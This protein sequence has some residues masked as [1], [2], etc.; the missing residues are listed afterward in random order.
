M[1]QAPEQRPPFPPFTLSS[2]IEK[3]RK[4][5]DAWNSRDPARVALAY[6]TDSRCATAANFFKASRRLLN[7]LPANGRRSRTTG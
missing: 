7:F 2:A 6:T 4:A 1:R 3:A 5:E